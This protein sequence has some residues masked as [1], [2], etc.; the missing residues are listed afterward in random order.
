[1][2]NFLLWLSA[3]SGFLAGIH[4]SLFSNA[5]RREHM[6]VARGIRSYYQV[7]NRSTDTSVFLRR[8][9]HRLEKGLIM[10]PRRGQFASEYIQA[11]VKEY[12]RLLQ[13]WDYFN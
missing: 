11:T 5:F 12:S 7:L 6:A 4:Y 8:N 2:R 3:R 1:M 10:R 13:Q 9:I